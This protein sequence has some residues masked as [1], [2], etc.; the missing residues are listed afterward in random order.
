MHEAG[1]SYRCI[2]IGQRRV[3]RRQFNTVRW[4]TRKTTIQVGDNGASQRWFSTFSVK[5]FLFRLWAS[6]TLKRAILC[7]KWFFFSAEKGSHTNQRRYQIM[8]IKIHKDLNHYFNFSAVCKLMVVKFSY[9][10]S[11]K[12]KCC[13]ISQKVNAAKIIYRFSA[14]S[15]KINSS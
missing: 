2:S 3:L 10:N 4:L 13:K 12:Q 5:L 7:I 1:K 14:H 8:I 6:P 15:S 11:K 9:H